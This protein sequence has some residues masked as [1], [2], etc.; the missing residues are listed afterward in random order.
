MVSLI[1]VVFLFVVM[2]VFSGF[3]IDL[4]SVFPFLQWIQWL[5]AFRYATNIISIN[6]F[7]GLS[8][9]STNQT[10]NNCQIAGEH[11]LTL[12]DIPHETDWDLWSNFVALLVMIYLFLTM[13]YIQLLRMKKY[14]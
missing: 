4:K 3:L 14:K 5:S 10:N 1:I 13:T 7:R 11:F 2:M 9:C 8:L 6:E 12:R